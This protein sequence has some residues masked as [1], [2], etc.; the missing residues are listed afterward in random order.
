MTT[1]PVVEK[2][3]IDINLGAGV[4]ERVRQELADWT[5]Q[6]T[7]AE[8]VVLDDLKALTKRPGLQ[9]AVTTDDQAGACYPI[10]RLLPVSDGLC[11]VGADHNL[12]HV[13]EIDGYATKKGRLPEFSV[14]R[15]TMSS[16]GL[17]GSS[18]TFHAPRCF[19][20]TSKYVVAVHESGL[21]GITNKYWTISVA[22]KHSGNII[23]KYLYTNS[24]VGSRMMAVVSGDTVHMVITDGVGA[25]YYTYLDLSGTLPTE[26]GIS[27]PTGVNLAGG[28]GAV[29]PGGIVAMSGGACVVATNL[30]GTTYL[31]RFSSAGASTATGSIA[32]FT[33]TG[34][35]T[36]G[37]SVY[38]S[39]YDA[40]PVL[41]LNVVDA[42][43][44]VTRTVTTAIAAVAG[45]TQ[46]R[47]STDASGNSRLVSYT[48]YNIAGA[49]YHPMPLVYRC[50]SADVAFTQLD[51]RG[52]AGWCEQA[53]PFYNSLTDR[54]YVLVAS[55]MTGQSG[56]AISRDAAT[57]SS[58]V[59]VDITESYVTA[60]SG[61]VKMFRPAAVVDTYTGVLDNTDADYGN[62]LSQPPPTVGAFDSYN[63][64]IGLQ[65]RSS[66][67][68][69]VYDAILLKVK[70]V[71]AIN[72]DKDVLSGS[73]TTS[74]DGDQPAEMGFHETPAVFLTVGGAGS[75]D[76]GV[77]NYI[78]VLE[79]RD[80]LG[81]SHFSRTSRASTVTPGIASAVTVT[82]KWP[83][84]TSHDTDSGRGAIICH[85]YRTTAGGTVY[86]QI[87]SVN[88]AINN[89]FTDTVTDAALVARPQP[90]RQPGINGTAL[91]RHAPRS[92][93]HIV[94]H[95]DRVFYANGSNVYYSS[96]A[97]DGEAPWFNPQFS[98]AVP[99][100]SGDITALASMDGVLV[101]FKRD[102]IFIVDGD[103]PAENGGNGTEFSPPRKVMTEFG[104]LDPRTL[105]Y[106]PKGLMY[107]SPRGFELLDRSLQVLQ[108]G[109]DITRTANAYPYSGGACFDQVNSRCLFPVGVS[110]D[111]YGRITYDS[112]GRILCYDAAAEA[113]TTWKPNSANTSGYHGTLD[114]CSARVFLAGGTNKER[115][116]ACTDYYT[117]YFSDSTYL[118]VVY[119][120]QLKLE[121]G[122]VRMDSAQDRVRISD[123]LALCKKSSNHNLVLSVAYDYSDSYSYSKTFT[124]ATINS[125]SLEQ[126]ELEVPSQAKMAMRFK[127]TDSAPADT[128]TYPVT[129]GA[130]PVVLALSV[131]MGRRGGGAKL[132]AD[133]KG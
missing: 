85:V 122:W 91:D 103:G 26:S 17:G 54:H 21:D 73:V 59:L 105:V 14:T 53:Q 32:T 68:S 100:G 62:W 13:D 102:S 101:V 30:G 69:F 63:L 106:M 34:I 20:A 107:R 64:V 3:V 23:R 38:L 60:G 116:F 77:H 127:V 44:A 1:P 104:C 86:Y 95:K 120:S 47:V 33:T 87:G 117:F 108:I 94:R 71:V 126:L 90:F 76:A 55:Q 118:D 15:K 97:V 6:L 74:Y 119:Y 16:W 7:T 61:G 129:T 124:P 83:G 82:L 29:A 96:F 56:A 11:F 40:T 99:G 2:Q 37:T 93:S 131:R 75:V 112:D 25:A 72:S 132:S 41:A 46:I 35:A 79:Y 12:Y 133:Q 28:A 43:L 92:S 8:N 9:Y 5:K 123:F 10:F 36:D 19:G 130:G 84:V 51:V 110:V 81:R 115:A 48:R 98:F 31:E 89:T 39:G 58:V 125:L 78:A 114:V 50:N 22:D 128:V 66:Y 18:S 49:L 42:T 121:S 88:L 27:W 52:L 80:M 65:Q 111:S 109:Q 24:V 113:W 57:A 70:D 4:N 45:T 67:L